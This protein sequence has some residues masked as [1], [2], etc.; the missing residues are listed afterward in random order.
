MGTLRA[1]RADFVSSDLRLAAHLARPSAERV[2]SSRPGLVICH[3]FPAAP[4]VVGS[5][6][7][8]YGQ[9]ADRIAAEAGWTALTF[10]CRG[11]GRSEGDF[12]LWCIRFYH[13]SEELSITLFGISCRL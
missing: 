4:E 5:S 7:G 6:A 13:A 11:V 12:S 8:T 2:A 9:L 1:V 10:S 3:G